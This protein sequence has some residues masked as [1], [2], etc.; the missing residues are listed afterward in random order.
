MADEIHKALRKWCQYRIDEDNTP[1]EQV[2]EEINQAT[3]I[4]VNHILNP[5]C[6]GK[7]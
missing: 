7:K 2:I 3:K 1:S 6:I 5:I 4:I